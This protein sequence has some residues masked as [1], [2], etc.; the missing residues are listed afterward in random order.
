MK[1]LLDMN[2]APR[3]C[4]YLAQEGIS[5]FIGRALVMAKRQMPRSW[6]R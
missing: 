3:W 2:L 4:E 1:L 6:L 5:R